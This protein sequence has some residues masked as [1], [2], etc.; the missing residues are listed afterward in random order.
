MPARVIRN[1]IAV[2]A[3]ESVIAHLERHLNRT[4]LRP[5]HKSEEKFNIFRIR[6]EG[7]W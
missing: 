3:K 6:L 2:V 4:R 5:T 1:K 7:G